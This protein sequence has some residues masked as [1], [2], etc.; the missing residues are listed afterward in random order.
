M[1]HPLHLLFLLGGLYVRV[2]LDQGIIITS[3]KILESVV[4][5]YQ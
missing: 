2:Y 4:G 1:Y 5:S 3:T